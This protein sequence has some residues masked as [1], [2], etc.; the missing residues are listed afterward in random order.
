MFKNKSR[1]SSRIS[2]HGEDGTF[3]PYPPSTVKAG[4]DK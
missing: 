3:Q 1:R 4:K 2:K